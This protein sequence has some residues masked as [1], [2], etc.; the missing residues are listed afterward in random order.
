MMTATL[1]LPPRLKNER[2]DS[3]PTENFEVIHGR[4]F[5]GTPTGFLGSYVVSLLLLRLGSYVQQHQLGTAF[6]EVLFELSP[7]GPL[8]RRPDLAFVVR[9]RLIHLGQL[10][11]DPPACHVV[12]NLAVEL[13]SPT[14][15]AS[16]L[17]R[18]IEDYF[19]AEVELVWVIRRQQRCNH[20]YKLPTQVRILTEAD[21]LLGEPAVPGFRLRIAELF[22]DFLQPQDARTARIAP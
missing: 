7:E 22:A 15:S 16:D 5:E 6:V 8:Q 3:P 12:P 19:A 20:V 18:K 10:S 4:S 14:N 21:E 13:V 9:D 11:E 2:F 1:T 17:L